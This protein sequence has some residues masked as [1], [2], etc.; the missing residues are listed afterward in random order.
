MSEEKKYVS[1]FHAEDAGLEDTEAIKVEVFPGNDAE[2]A[3][4][5]FTAM[6]FQNSMSMLYTKLKKKL[7]DDSE[8]ECND[9]FTDC[10]VVRGDAKRIAVPRKFFRF[11]KNKKG[12][13]TKSMPERIVKYVKLVYFNGGPTFEEQLDRYLSNVP[14]NCWV[15]DEV[16]EETE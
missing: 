9:D 3:V 13:Y 15:D 6:V 4:V 11:E 5:A 16:E 12:Q 1:I 7:K 10:I 14:D 2:D 8:W